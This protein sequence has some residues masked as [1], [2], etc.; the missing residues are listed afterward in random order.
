MAECILAVA[1]AEGAAFFNGHANQKME[2]LAA[3][4]RSKFIR[5][6]PNAIFVIAEDNDTRLGAVRKQ[7]LIAFDCWNAHC[8]NGARGAL[9]THCPIFAKIN[10]FIGIQ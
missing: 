7:V 5:F 3:K 9:F 4:H 10:L 6:R 2:R 1:L 8:G